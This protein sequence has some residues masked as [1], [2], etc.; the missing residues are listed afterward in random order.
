MTDKKRVIEA[1]LFSSAAP[2]SVR[3]IREIIDDKDSEGTTNERIMALITQLNEDYTAYGVAFKIIEV[4]DGYMIVT[5]AQYSRWIKKLY[6]ITKATKLSQS[7]LQTLAIIAYK[8]PI[9]RVDIDTIR[10]ANSAGVIA[11][12]LKRELI[13]PTGRLNVAGRPIL[14]DVSN[15]FFTYFG[16]KSKNELPKLREIEEMLNEAS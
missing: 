11:T 4:K 1:L 14:Y 7:S 15:N 16:L 5:R 6:T 9:T 10:G 3:R 8:G 2:L 12:L 13:K